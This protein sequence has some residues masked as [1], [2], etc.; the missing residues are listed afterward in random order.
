MKLPSRR[1]RAVGLMP[2]TGSN[3]LVS[4]APTGALTALETPVE[5]CEVPPLPVPW[6]LQHPPLPGL[7]A[8]FVCKHGLFRS[9]ETCQ[10]CILQAQARFFAALTSRFHFRDA[11]PAVGFLT[12]VYWWDEQSSR[13]E[14]FLVMAS[15]ELRTALDELAAQVRR[16]CAPNA[17]AS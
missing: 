9:H 16:G 17:R 6:A 10:L 11:S 4:A 15:S 7:L 12:D 3:K 1:K 14:T 2:G 8:A 5:F 13:K